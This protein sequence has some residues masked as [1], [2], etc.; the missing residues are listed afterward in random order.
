MRRKCRGVL[1]PLLRFTNCMTCWIGIKPFGANQDPVRRVEA[2]VVTAGEI[3]PGRRHVI[4]EG[5]VVTITMTVPAILTLMSLI[6]V[7]GE[8][9]VVAAT[10]INALLVPEVKV[11]R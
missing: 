6:G 2:I 3:I 4:S 1:L 9:S 11:E 8:G 10:T 5:I 7:H